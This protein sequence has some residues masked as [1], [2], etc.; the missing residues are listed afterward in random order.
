MLLVNISIC[1][2]SFFLCYL[3]FIINY[4]RKSEWASE[5]K[6]GSGWKWLFENIMVSYMWSYEMH[7]DVSNEMWWKV[8]NFLQF[9]KLLCTRKK[10]FFAC[11]ICFYY[12]IIDYNDYWNQK[13]EVV[14][15]NG[16]IQ[17]MQDK[18]REIPLCSC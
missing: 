1:E 10:I 16:S 3:F 4:R 7:S 2:I 13:E 14:F 17:L 15:Q 9:C 18:I 8:K 12:L 6:S 5:E 11:C